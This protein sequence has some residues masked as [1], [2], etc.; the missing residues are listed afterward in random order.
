MKWITD[1][2]GPFPLRAKMKMANSSNHFPAQKGKDFVGVTIML[3]AA[4]RRGFCFSYAPNGGQVYT[5]NCNV[6]PFEP[7]SLQPEP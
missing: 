3:M 1:Q 5:A 2:P 4:A 6:F 7:Q